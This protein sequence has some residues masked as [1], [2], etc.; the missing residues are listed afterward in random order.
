LSRGLE[1]APEHAAEG[2]LL[3]VVVED[4]GGPRVSDGGETGE[5]QQRIDIGTF[6]REFIRP[7]RGVAN[8][9]AEVETDSAKEHL[10][11]LINSI[12]TNRHG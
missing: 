3:S 8:V 11:R 5:L 6:Q 10:T 1:I 4:E 12:E 7:G 2:W 9:F